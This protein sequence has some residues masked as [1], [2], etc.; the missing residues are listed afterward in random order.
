MSLVVRLA[1]DSASLTRLAP[2]S[3]WI[4]A[5]AGELLLLGAGLL[6]ELGDDG[7]VVDGRRGGVGICY[8]HGWFL[9]D[10]MRRSN[11]PPAEG[12]VTTSTDRTFLRD[13]TTLVPS[14]SRTQSPN[15]SI[16]KP[17]REG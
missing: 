2:S 4:C 1:R 6:L 13:L 16:D 8:C 9:S 12:R 10:W 11:D 17:Q 7:R 5:D 3:S 14:A 15:A